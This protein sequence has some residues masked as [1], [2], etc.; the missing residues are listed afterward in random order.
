MRRPRLLRPRLIPIVAGTAL[1]V[2][3]LLGSAAGAA[4]G[5]VL[6]D[7]GATHPQAITNPAAGECVWLG[8]GDAPYDVANQTD[9]VIALYGP[10]GCNGRPVVTLAPGEYRELPEGTDVA[11]LQAQR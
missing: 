1:L 10:Q 3:S 5:Q 6:F 7:T 4:E 2:V 9:T 8:A 11:H